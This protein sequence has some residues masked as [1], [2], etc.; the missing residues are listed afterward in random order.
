MKKVELLAPAGS[1]EALIA[2]VQNGC[3]A[4]YLGGTMFGAR[5]FANNFD[6]EQI[7]QAI[8]YAHGYGVKVYVTMNTLIMET[9]MD[10]A[11]AYAKFLYEQEVD[12]LIIQDIG[13]MDVL[14]QS[15]PSL[16][17]HASTQMH[18]HNEQGIELL[19]MLGAKRVVVPRESSIEEVKRLSNEGLD[20]EVFVQGA[21]CVSY[22]G[23]CFM[24]AKKLSRSGNRGA[25]AQMC[26]M[27][28]KLVK[29]NNGSYSYVDQEGEYLL[30]PKDLN[31]LSLVPQLMD[32]GIASFKIEGR[33]K[34]PAYVALMVSLYR[35]AIDA[36]QEKQQFHQKDAD[37]QMR[38]MFNRDFTPGHLF[39]KNGSALMNFHRP[40]HM[41][42]PVGKVTHG[43]AT[44]ITIVL[45]DTLCQGDGIRF[46]GMKEDTGCMV[47]K[48]YKQG[49]LVKEAYAKDCIELEFH[50]FVEKGSTVVKTSDKQQLKELQTISDQS[51][52]KVKARMEVE[53][54][55]D[56]HLSI[57]IIDEEGFQV[58][59]KSTSLVE[60]AHKTPL[61][62]ERLE[63]QLR[64][65]GDTIFELTQVRIIM[66][67]QATISIKEINQIRRDA[68]AQLCELRQKRSY[69]KVYGL[70]QR[71]IHVSQKQELYNVVHTQEQ[72]EACRMQG[73]HH[74]FVDGKQLFEDIYQKDKTIGYHGPRV[75]K[76]A[77]PS[78]AIMFC[79]SGGIRNTFGIAERFLNVT[80][81]F[82]A[83]FLF[84]HGIQ[85]VTISS[86][87]QDEQVQELLSAFSKRYHSPG[88]FIYYAYGREELM[89]SDYCMVNTCVT[90][91]GK[92]NCSLCKGSNRYYLEDIAKQGYPLFGDDACRMHILDSEPT[93]SLDKFSSLS[94]MISFTTETKEEVIAICQ[95]LQ[96]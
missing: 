59:Y 7:C 73:M 27:K 20:V 86:E 28:Y 94:K 17:L 44:R 68:F 75:M 37:K 70:Y 5:A 82:S 92:Q 36:Y 66:D 78:V 22:S 2:A 21:L 29:E 6:N 38:M 95:A 14:H 47:N 10:A 42:I 54:K 3:D 46:L 77:Y 84:A 74:I 58:L 96:T 50:G 91:N 32:A 15:F 57:N 81:S 93:R 4:V 16:E 40:N 41:G 34:R 88:N 61:A 51:L 31:T 76:E 90:N 89:V 39:H 19:R 33:M 69:E 43:K 80:N 53:M 48:M 1:M 26:R 56:R 9:E 60:R 52:R 64:K 23:Q 67:E 62:K 65:C 63:T 12:A 49:R 45:T 35:Q 79:E 85:A 18:I 11:M 13:F 72:Y 71:E 83:A 24:S 55:I 8:T 87:I 25:C 30:S